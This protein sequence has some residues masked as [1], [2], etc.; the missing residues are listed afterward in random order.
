MN[1]KNE[2]LIVV[3]SY[4]PSVMEVPSL[5]IGETIYDNMTKNRNIEESKVYL[6]QIIK[7][8]EIR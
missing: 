6:C 5:E 2:Y 3:N 7:P 4:I 8:K 1:S